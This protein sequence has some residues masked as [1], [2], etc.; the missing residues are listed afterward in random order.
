MVQKEIKRKTKLYT[1][2]AVLI[3]VI[4]VSSIYAATSP[5]T[6]YGPMNVP[7]MKTFASTDELKNYLLANAQNNS[8][9]DR[10]PPVPSSA[11]SSGNSAMEYM[12]KPEVGDLAATYSGAGYSRTNIQVDGVDESDIVKT[13]GEYIYIITRVSTLNS[14]KI[15]KADSKDLYIVGKI[16]FVNSEPDYTS[17]VLVTCSTRLLGMYLS[18]D[19]NKLVVLGMNVYNSIANIGVRSPEDV[20][21]HKFTESDFEIMRSSTKHSVTSFVYVYDVSNRV[22]PKLD[23]NVTL[24]SNYDSFNSRM[25]GDYV[26]A[27]IS[28]PLSVDDTSVTLPQISTGKVTTEIAPS[29]IYH[30]EMQ[31]RCS[32][33]STFV[34]VNIMNASEQP[35]TM[36]ILMGASSCMYVST[37]NMY[38]TFSNAGNTAIYRIA[39]N[40]TQPTFKAQGIVPGYVLNQY[41]MDEYNDYFRIATSVFTNIRDRFWSDSD[42]NNLYVLNMDLE[43]VG[44]V[45]DLASGERIYSTR[46]AG[47]KAY[48]VTFKQIDPFFVIDLKDPTSPKVAGELKI[49]GYSSYLHPYNENYIIGIGRED[50][51]VKLSFFDVT[52]MNN[53]TEIAKYL[54]DGSLGNH[55]VLCNS[56]ALSDPK[57][58]LFDLQKHLLVIPASFNQDGYTFFRGVYAFHVSPEDG[59]T[60][61][62]KILQQHKDGNQNMINGRSNIQPSVTRSLYIGNTLYTISS[63]SMQ[64]TSLNDFK[65]IAKIDL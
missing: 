45:E 17:D 39:I 33:V 41:S 32:S 23:R 3:S 59:F 55:S 62:S 21:N 2:A 37:N 50:F 6:M 51:Y 65:F 34:G 7:L 19:G 53:P 54:I 48:V 13:D 9:A 42:Y 30:T 63:D 47:D 56:A 14:V 11:P 15:V 35:A 36:T 4:L 31:D 44:K 24:S 25:I 40:D 49:P 64:L 20:R 12:I 52:D 28:Q 46:F 60:L 38:V 1:I 26:Y 8:P 43:V 61:Q 18:D 57:A 27:V 58:F 10:P 5:I 22:A 16:D 29:S